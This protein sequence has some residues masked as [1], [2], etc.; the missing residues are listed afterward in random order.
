MRHWVSGH[1]EGPQSDLLTPPP[2]GPLDT[3][4]DWGME[5]SL[6]ISSASCWSGLMP[7]ALPG[8]LGPLHIGRKPESQTWHP[9]GFS[10]PSF[11]ETLAL[12]EGNGLPSL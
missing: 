4:D 12:L 6:S 9:Q 10:G 2:S 8:P 5:G 7:E 3:L 11:P 1:Q